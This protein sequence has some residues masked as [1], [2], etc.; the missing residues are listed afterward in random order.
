MPR[1][2]KLIDAN[3]NNFMFQ[4]VVVGTGA[5]GSHFVRGLLQDIRTYGNKYDKYNFDLT[6]V[7]E[8]KVEAKNTLNQLFIDEDINE[9][10]VN[11][12]A[13]RY[14]D[15]Y[16]IEIKTV[17]QFCKDLDMLQR[18]FTRPNVGKK[19]KV[20]PIL[21]G[22]V[23]NNKTRQLFHQ[24]FYSA[25]VNDLI[26]LD[27][28][29]EGIT[30]KENPTITE[31]EIFQ[32]DRSGFSGQIVCGLKWNGVTIL[33]PV[34]DVYANIL[35][36]ANTSFPGESCGALIINNPQRC[37]TNKFAAQLANNFMNNLLHVKSIF[38]HVINFNAQLCVSRPT[39]LTEEQDEFF[40]IV[41]KA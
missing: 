31:E 36:D 6:L 14:G 3:N 5:N 29:V 10:K 28:G 18:L 7:D 12:L 22:M 2:I 26:W 16:N 25:I 41:N 8:D 39:Y 20:I 30:I 34:T 32:I 17:S 40:R 4:I 24:F 19:R 23:D 1:E 13:D 37:A 11:A 21:I 27:A 38:F 35:E 9:Y 15:V 33:E